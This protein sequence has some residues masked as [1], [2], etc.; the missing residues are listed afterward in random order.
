[1]LGVA[2]TT[3]VNDSNYKYIGVMVVTPDQLWKAFPTSTVV[4]DDS[5]EVGKDYAIKQQAEGE[6][7]FT[8]TEGSCGIYY[9]P[10]K[11][12]LGK[13]ATAGDCVLFKFD[14]TACQGRL[15]N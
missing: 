2:T 4:P 12:S 13:G 15:G 9:G 6:G 7:E 8:S 3:G 1:V 14:S 5:L 11:E 10:D